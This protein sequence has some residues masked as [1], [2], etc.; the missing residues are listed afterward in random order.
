V[1]K[2]HRLVLAAGSDYFRARLCTPPPSSDGLAK[3]VLMD[4]DIV[5]VEGVDGSRVP[6]EREDRERVLKGGDEVFVKLVDGVH[7]EGDTELMDGGRVLREQV[8]AGEEK[9]MEA[10][11]EFLYKERFDES[12]PL[13]DM[14]IVIKVHFLSRELSE[15]VIH[16]FV[17]LKDWI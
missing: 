3:R 1:R 10:F 5:F 15:C 17:C 6:L 2:L 9:G 4:E 8:A 12:L 7:T 14:L 13:S 11:L 16:L